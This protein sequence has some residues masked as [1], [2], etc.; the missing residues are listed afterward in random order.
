MHEE[1]LVT[2]GI[3]VG[4]DLET[5]LAAARASGKQNITIF[6]KPVRKIVA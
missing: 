5:Y 6:D 4:D 1:K 2:S 3:Y